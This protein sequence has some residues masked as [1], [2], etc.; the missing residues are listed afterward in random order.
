VSQG[1]LQLETIRPTDAGESRD[2]NESRSGDESRGGDKSDRE[3]AHDAV[4]LHVLDPRFPVAYDFVQDLQVAGDGRVVV[5]RWSGVVHVVDPEGRVA[6]SRLPDL[7]PHGLYYS[8]AVEGDRVCATYCADVSVVCGPAPVPGQSRSG[9][10][11]RELRDGGSL[12]ILR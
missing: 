12:A 11:W 7:D 4:E 8:A 3:E 1:R 6:S 2:G 10:H 5:T 9:A